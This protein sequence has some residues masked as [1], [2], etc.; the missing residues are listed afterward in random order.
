MLMD[1]VGYM[2]PVE[3]LCNYILCTYLT[4]MAICIMVFS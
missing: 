1:V 4:Q 3:L 2:W